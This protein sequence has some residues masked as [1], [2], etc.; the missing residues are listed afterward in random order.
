MHKAPTPG[1]Q[2]SAGSTDV[3]E[4]APLLNIASWMKPVILLSDIVQGLVNSQWPTFLSLYK[5]EAICELLWIVCW[6][7]P[8]STASLTARVFQW[9]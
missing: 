8:N 5:E 7:I 9:A 1:L 2:V 4:L 3:T 6:W